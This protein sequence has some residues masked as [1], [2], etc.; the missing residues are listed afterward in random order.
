MQEIRLSSLIELIN[1]SKFYQVGETNL[2]ALNGINFNLQA[3]EMTA[4]MGASGSGKSTLMNILGFLDQ[5]TSGKYFFLGQDVSRLND[6]ELATIR[7]QKIG[8]VF[9]SFFLLSRSNALE[10]VMLPLFYRG[11]PRIEAKELAME[12]L[13]KVH[14]AHLAHHQPNQLSGGQQQRV[15]IAR[16]LVGNPDII[17]ADEPTGALDSQTGNEIMQLFSELNIKEKRS[18]V[19]ITHDKNISQRCQRVVMLSDGEIV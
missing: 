18:I 17:L 12:M 3:G 14:V 16:A 1:V 10:N 4:I 7:N 19:I 15:A 11:K 8:F 9:Q 6:Y 5:C 2:A 13:E